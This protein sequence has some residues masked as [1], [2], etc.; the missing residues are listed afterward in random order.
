MDTDN[1]KNYRPVSNL[2]FLGKLIE[3]VVGIRLNKHMAGNH[4]HS[5]FQYGYEKGIQRRHF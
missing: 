2:L 4:L 3:R 5:D 1:L